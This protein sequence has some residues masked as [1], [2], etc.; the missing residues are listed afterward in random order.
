VDTES[1]EDLSCFDIYCGDDQT[2]FIQ[3]SDKIAV[4]VCNT[5]RHA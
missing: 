2:L 4:F 5:A 1:K 3:S